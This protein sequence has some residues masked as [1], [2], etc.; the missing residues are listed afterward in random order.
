MIPRLARAS[1]T[2][3]LVERWMIPVTTINSSRRLH[4]SRN[5]VHPSLS[6]HLYCSQPEQQRPPSLQMAYPFPRP[7]GSPHTPQH[8]K[9]MSSPRSSYGRG[10]RPPC[11]PTRVMLALFVS[12]ICLSL[13]LWSRGPSPSLQLDRIPFPEDSVV[14]CV[15]QSRSHAHASVH[16]SRKLS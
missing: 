10:A 4:K 14:E 12:A 11:T 5:L 2:F 6:V 9:G 1:A 13:L 8:I 3:H 15:S 7:A 16:H